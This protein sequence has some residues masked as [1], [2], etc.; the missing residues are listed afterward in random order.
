VTHKQHLVAVVSTAVCW[1]AVALTWFIGA[2]YNASHGPRQRGRAPFRTLDIAAVIVTG[3]IFWAIFQGLPQH[4]W[5]P[6]TGRSPRAAL[7]RS[8]ACFASASRSPPSTPI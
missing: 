6:L 8:S 7:P 3:A 5:H 4:T 1:S 2:L